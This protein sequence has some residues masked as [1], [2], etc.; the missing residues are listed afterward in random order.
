MKKK[1]GGCVCLYGNSELLSCCARATALFR[2][3]VALII[4]INKF[5]KT[6]SGRPSTL[7]STM[8]IRHT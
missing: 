8:S 2:Y 6:S 4:H 7:S 3:S 5:G 1:C